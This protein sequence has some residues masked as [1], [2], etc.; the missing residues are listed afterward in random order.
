MS[1]RFSTVPPVILAAAFFINSLSDCV[2]RLLFINHFLAGLRLFTTYGGIMPRKKRT[3]VETDKMDPN[4]QTV[5]V[6]EEEPPANLP[7]IKR[8]VWID[9]PPT[10]VVGEELDPPV[11]QKNWGDP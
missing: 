4:T 11:P 5:A 1:F 3:S 2:K 7:P 8:P 9:G 10:P 6:A